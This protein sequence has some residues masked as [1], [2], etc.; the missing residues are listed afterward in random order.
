MDKL[1]NMDEH[2]D[3]GHAERQGVSLIQGELI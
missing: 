2:E 1:V 3:N